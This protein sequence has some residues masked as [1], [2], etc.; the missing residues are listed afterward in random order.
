MKAHSMDLPLYKRWL[1]DLT[2]KNGK[3]LSDG[4]RHI[5]S[6]SVSKFLKT[7]PDIDQIDSYNEFIINGSIH[8]RNNH[9]A[10]ALK[11]FIMYKFN[12]E[13]QDADAAMGITIPE[14]TSYTKIKNELLEKIIKPEEQKSLKRERMHLSDDKVMEILWNMDEWKHRVIG[15]IMYATGVRIGDVLRLEA[16]S[17]IMYEDHYGKKTMRLNI[18]GKR[19]LKNVTYIHDPY[20][21]AIIDEYI[22]QAIYYTNAMD[23]ERKEYYFLQNSS[24]G[25]H[26]QTEDLFTMLEMNYRWYYMDF[27]KSMMKAGVLSKDFSPHGVRHTFAKKIWDMDKDIH[28]LQRMLN[29]SDIRS[30]I[31]YLNQ[32]GLMNIDYLYKVQMG[33]DPPNIKRNGEKNEN[34]SQKENNDSISSLAK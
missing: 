17:G 21:Q 32:R 14:N 10:Y 25:R 5:Y 9:Y 31:R 19:K 20:F 26:V 29:H 18:L 4:T 11:Y 22:S 30:S 6:E 23:S 13:S 1:D 12:K 8:K 34:E 24:H 2:K 28:M 16:P 7:N 27:K 33:S 15:L 3:K